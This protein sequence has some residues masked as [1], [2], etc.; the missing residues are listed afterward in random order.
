[1]AKR[2]KEAQESKSGIVIDGGISY[3][4]AGI[5]QEFEESIIIKK[6]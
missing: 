6:G 4:C 3:F 2:E 5:R 1:L